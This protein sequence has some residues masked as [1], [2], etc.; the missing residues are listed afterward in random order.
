MTTTAP[1]TFGGMKPQ[2]TMA[3]M[4]FQITHGFIVSHCLQ[5]EQYD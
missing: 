5:C 3:S 4:L 1:Q 2:L